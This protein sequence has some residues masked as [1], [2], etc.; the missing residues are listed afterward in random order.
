MIYK[1]ENTLWHGKIGVPEKYIT[2]ALK[3]KEVLILEYKKGKMEIPYT[4]IK[5]SIVGYSPFFRD[6]FGG[7]DYK[8]VYFQWKDDEPIQTNKLL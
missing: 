3:K 1:K 2:A 8:L 5:G 4:E 7:K 6:K